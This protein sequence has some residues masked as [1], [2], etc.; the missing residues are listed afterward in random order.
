MRRGCNFCWA[1]FERETDENTIIA[2][3]EHQKNCTEEV[4]Y[5]DDNNADGYDDF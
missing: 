2:L 5:R 1:W 4:P 3:K